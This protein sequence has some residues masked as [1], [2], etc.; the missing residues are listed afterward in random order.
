[1]LNIRKEKKKS[2]I[3]DFFSNFVNI[4]EIVSYIF[5]IFTLNE[6]LY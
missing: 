5:K 3:E 2:K 6:K 1:M 4:L